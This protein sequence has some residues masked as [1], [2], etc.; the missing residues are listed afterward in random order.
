MRFSRLVSDNF[1]KKE[2]IEILWEIFQFLTLTYDFQNENI[3]KSKY[4]CL[5]RLTFEVFQQEEQI[6]CTGKKTRR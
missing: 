5:H 2:F 3:A 6:K 4:K 1:S